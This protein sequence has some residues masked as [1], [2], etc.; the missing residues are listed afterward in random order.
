MNSCL[1]H[2]V[3]FIA[4]AL[5]SFAAAPLSA[6]VEIADAQTVTLPWTRSHGLVLPDNTRLRIDVTL[7]PPN[8]TKPA[9][10]FPVFYYSGRIS[11][12]LMTDTMR[13]MGDSQVH[14]ILVG[15][16]REDAGTGDRP[17]VPAVI[18]QF[19][20]PEFRYRYSE[21]GD[22]TLYAAIGVELGPIVPRDASSAAAFDQWIFA[23]LDCPSAL[24]SMPKSLTIVRAD[25]PGV[26][27]AKA[28][29]PR[30]SQL[31]LLEGHDAVT[32]VPESAVRAIAFS[33]QPESAKRR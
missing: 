3:Y 11:P 17:I 10:G 24:A 5:A 33:L 22:R 26:A 23:H 6:Q 20:Q 16:A 32:M 14:A 2:V 25:C 30:S 31:V 21:G 28:A 7:P 18:A 12:A 1:R 4:G 19:V 27:S 29:K 8:V 15:V 9:G 13:R